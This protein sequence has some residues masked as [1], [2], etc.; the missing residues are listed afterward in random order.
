MAVEM[1]LNLPENLIESARKFGGATNQRVEAVLADALEM[2]LPMI[3]DSPSNIPYP[4]TS[5][6]SDSEVLELADSKMDAAQNQRL[7]ELQAKGKATGLSL[8][9]RYEL[10]ALFRI[11]QIGLL[12]KSEA[13]AE[14]V[15]RGLR[16]PMAA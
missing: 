14:A 13:M 15:Q 6:L 10:L 3:E 16:E 11:Y 2:V 12:R 7:G 1:T 8:A 9:E 5:D 4:P